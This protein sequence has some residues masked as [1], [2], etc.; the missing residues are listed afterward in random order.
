MAYSSFAFLLKAMTKQL[1]FLSAA[2]VLLTVLFAVPAS[3]VELKMICLDDKTSYVVTFDTEREVFNMTHPKMGTQ[4]K[5][6][7]VQ[8]DEDGVLVQVSTPVFGGD[9]DMLALWSAKEKWIRLFYGN[10]S[11]VM[12]ACR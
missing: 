1:T 9:R 12:H 7:R 6:K 3:A 11:N 10:G 8:N 2:A 4:F 5:V